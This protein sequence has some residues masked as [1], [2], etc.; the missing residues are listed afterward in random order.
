MRQLIGSLAK[1]ISV[2]ALPVFTESVSA[3]PFPHAVPHAVLSKAAHI[4]SPSPAVNAIAAKTP[5][6]GEKRTSMTLLSKIVGEVGEHTVT[7]REVRINDAVERAITHHL[8]NHPANSKAS[9]SGAGVEENRV[10]SGTEKRFPAEVGR[11]LDEWIVYLEAKLLA[12]QPATKSDVLSA[13]KAIQEFWAGK[14]NWHDLEVSN[15]ELREMVDRKILTKGFVKL[16]N[17]P[18][19]AP[20]SDDEALAYYRKNRLRFGSLPFSSFKDSI[21]SFLTKS[22]T[23]RRLAE[24]REV[25]RRK[26]KVRNLIAG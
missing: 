18:N 10:L 12:V 17:D 11:V 25:L 6:V 8:T 20:I 1:C 26:Y 15:E 3:E 4:G 9:E 7:S 24:W 19:L 14:D 2:F 13:I 22:Q 16:K 23:E 21:K 5:M